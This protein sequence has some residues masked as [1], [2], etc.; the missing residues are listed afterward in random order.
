MG[1]GPSSKETTLHHYND[2]LVELI[3]RDKTVDFRGI[4]LQGTPENIANKE[5]IAYRCSELLEAMDADGVIVSID[6]WGNSHVDFTSTIKCISEKSIPVVG[7]SFVGKQ[8]DFVV[9]NKYMKSIVDINKN[10]E[11]IE[12]TVLGQN[13]TSE[14]DAY[15]A[16]E[17]LKYKI[18]KNRGSEL[19]EA[20]SHKVKKSLT[21]NSV[22][23]TDVISGDMFSIE[24]SVL[25]I[26]NSVGKNFLDKYSEIEAVHIRIL[27]PQDRDVW[28]N[29]ILDFC[30]IAVKQEGRLGSGSTVLINGVKVMLTAK[31]S[32]GFQ[33]SNIGSSEGILK[34][35]VVFNTKSTPR[36]NDIII[37]IDVELKE[38]SGRTKSGIFSAHL[39]CDEIIQHIRTELKLYG[40]DYIEKRCLEEIKNYDCPKVVLVKLVSGLGCMYDTAVFPGNPAG[41][42]SAK[43]IMDFGNIQIYISQNEYLDGIV[44]SL[45]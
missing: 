29:S 33:P 9:T 44:H 22:N 27:K 24:D 43:S 16:F 19:L 15:K 10:E 36:E 30:P 8:A 41:M 4:I 32:L 14:Y 18:S 17:I 40:G 2:P 37:N 21:I 25:S 34:D 39:I 1:I 45:T 26:D 12:T 20:K 28:V 7:I 31:E 6:S 35:K 11:G 38:G 42:I 3:S 23:I 5:L 13:T